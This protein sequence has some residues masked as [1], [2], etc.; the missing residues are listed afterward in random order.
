M[1]KVCSAS[2]QIKARNVNRAANGSQT[3]L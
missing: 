3:K 1:Q 2:S